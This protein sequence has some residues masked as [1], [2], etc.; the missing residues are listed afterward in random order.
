MAAALR[1]HNIEAIVV[2][3]AAEARDVV[4]GLIPDGAEV[5][6]GKSK[7]LEDLGLSSELVE[8]GRYDAIRPRLFAMDRATQGGEMRKL[9]AAPDFM[10][11]SV[12]AVTEDGTLVAA[13]AT[14][15]QLASY[16]AG[17]GRL[18]LVVGSQKIVPDLDA[19]LR[20]IDEVAFPYEN[21]QVRARLGVDTALEKVLLIYGEW[22]PGRT[23]VVL[24]RQPVG[25]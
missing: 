15:S 1:A 25:V 24:V 11:G 14:G 23:T 3:T 22:Q 16:A 17:A 7:T 19:A 10:L 2:D 5:H 4:L 12:A 13:S 9:V 21:A 8:S 18:I 6:S 20:R